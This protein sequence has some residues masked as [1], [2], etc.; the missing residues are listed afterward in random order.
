ML[1]ETLLVYSFSCAGGDNR[2]KPEGLS[3]ISR[4]AQAVTGKNAGSLAGEDSIWRF[5]PI[6]LL[7]RLRCV[8]S[9]PHEKDNITWL[10]IGDPPGDG[11]AVDRRH[12]AG[13]GERGCRLADLW[14]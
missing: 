14:Q 3:A 10:C 5:V 11:A 12:G 1:E 6:S 2:R 9:C 13:A 4:Q 7:T 8:I